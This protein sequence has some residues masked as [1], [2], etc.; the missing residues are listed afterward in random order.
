MPKAKQ[1]SAAKQDISPWA[2]AAIIAGLFL[3]VVYSAYVSGFLPFL[4]PQSEL[5][6]RIAAAVNKTGGDFNKLDESEKQYLN[7]MT[8]G[9]GAM[10]LKEYLMSKGK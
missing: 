10:A 3:L 9:R 8:N 5:G 7:K 6:R 4:K 2:A 1:K